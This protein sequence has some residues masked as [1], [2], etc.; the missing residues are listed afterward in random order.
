MQHEQQQIELLHHQPLYPVSPYQVDTPL[1][2]HTHYDRLYGTIQFLV[3]L[4]HRSESNITR[5][6]NEI[7]LAH[8]VITISDTKD[9]RIISIVTLVF[10]PG[11]FVSTLFSMTFFNQPSLEQPWGVTSKIWIYFVIS[12]ILTSFTFIVWF[13]GTRIWKGVVRIL[14]GR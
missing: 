8:T 12:G 14:L 13:W 2:F 11:T 1:P 7:Q 4:V 5:L 3:L 10:L 6:R 9:M